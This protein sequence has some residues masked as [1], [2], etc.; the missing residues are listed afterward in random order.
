MIPQRCSGI[1]VTSNSYTTNSLERYDWYVPKL[2]KAVLTYKIVFA[3]LTSP[4]EE[5]VQ[6][7][8]SMNNIACIQLSLK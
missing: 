2:S 5:F 1:R 4:Y 7:K 8:K 3:L 6:P